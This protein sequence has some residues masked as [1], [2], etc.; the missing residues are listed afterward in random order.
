MENNKV[1]TLFSAG[2]ARTEVKRSIFIS[3]AVPAKSERDA[4][5]FI[6]SI[7]EKYPDATHTVYAYVLRE[8]NTAR[9]SDDGE[10]HG[11]A[12]VP[13]L[14]V[15]RKENIFDAA[16]TV[17]RYFGGTLLG[18]GGLLRAYTAAAKAALDNA[19]CG[20]AV[21]WVRFALKISYRQND[22]V[23]HELK[24]A[25]VIIEGTSFGEDVTLTVSVP[26][27]KEEALISLARALVQGTPDMQKLGTFE[28]PLA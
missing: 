23:Q 1:M 9:F 12:G 7:R 27:S 19:H 11:T 6:S 8:N 16:I 25:G 4:L 14:E 10:P 26:R 3:S 21:T 15:L 2:T 13:V 22:K 5:D 17:T 18:A 20:I 24:K 28:A